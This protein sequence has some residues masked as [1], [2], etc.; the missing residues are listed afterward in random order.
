MTRPPLIFRLMLCTIFLPII[1]FVGVIVCV[2]LHGMPKD[3][4]SDP[5]TL[6][7]VPVFYF[8]IVIVALPFL[9]WFWMLWSGNWRRPILTAALGIAAFTVVLIVDEINHIGLF[10]AHIPPDKRT[11]SLYGNGIEGIDVFCNGVLLGQTPLDIRVDE[12]TAKVPQ[13]DTPPEQRWYKDDTSLY[14]WTPWDNFRKE[15][16]DEAKKLYESFNKQENSTARAVKKSQA[17]RTKYETGCRYWWSYRFADVQLI[18]TPEPFGGRSIMDHNA[19]FDDQASYHISSYNPVSLSD[20]FHVQLLVDVLPE[21]TPEQKADWNRHVLKYWSLLG[22]PLSRALAQAANQYRRDKNEPLAELYKTALYSTARLEYNLS[23]PPTEEECRRL[24]ETWVTES[25]WKRRFYLATYYESSGDIFQSETSVPSVYPNTLFPDDFHQTM[26][27]RKPLSEQWKKNKYRIPDAWGPVAYFSWK[28]KSPDYF[29]DFVRNAATTHDAVFALFDNQ[30]P[31]TTALFKTLLYRRGL[32]TAMTWRTYLYSTKIRTFAFCANPLVET[33]MRD[34]MFKA[35]SDPAHNDSSREMVERAIFDAIIWRVRRDDI[36]KDELA[37]WVGSLPFTASSKSL[38]SRL[39]QI[40]RATP[41]TFIEHLQNIAGNYGVLIETD[42]T[43]DEISKWCADLP[44]PNTGL[45]Q[46]LEDQM[47]R[48]VVT[49]LPTNMYG[50]GINLQQVYSFEGQPTGYVQ[51]SDQARWFILALL[52][53]DP[54]EGDPQIRDLVCRLWG[55][56]PVT[57]GEAIMTEYSSLR[58]LE[59]RNNRYGSREEEYSGGVGSINLPEYMLDW[60]LTSK[61]PSSVGDEPLPVAF[62]VMDT[63]W[64]WTLALCDSPKA[65]EILEKWASSPNLTYKECLETWR[66]RKALRQRKMEMFQDIVAGRMSPDDL[67]LPQPSWVWKDGK[68]VQTE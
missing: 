57:V 7:G 31:R 4:W 40:Y 37:D 20:N 3:I 47:E 32:S 35:L 5:T 48:I 67:L 68:Y 42:L 15:R 50:R 53:S 24:L 43:V 29:A 36:D 33:V 12:L 49:P 45:N 18:Q 54:P 9:L 6:H 62:K 59:R 30:N 2:A 21:L 64:A 46:F 1:I 10:K 44:N 52:R 56:D 60:I 11:I 55:I 13:W 61:K 22:Q 66:V 34:Y 41:H 51:A 58:L 19:S 8:P 39:M 23:N 16:F 28:D 63:R 38:I 14:T 26:P 65:G 25:A 27:I 17:A